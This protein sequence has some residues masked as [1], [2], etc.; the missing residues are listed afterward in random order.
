MPTKTD[1]SLWDLFMTKFRDIV[2]I[3]LFFATSI[4]W[5]VTSTTNKTKMKVVLEQNTQVINELKQEVKKINEYITKQS[6]LNGQIIQY[7]KEK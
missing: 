2:F 3:I 5:I 4:G 6:E 1:K 7:M